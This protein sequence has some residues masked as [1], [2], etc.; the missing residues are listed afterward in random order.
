MALDTQVGAGDLVETAARTAVRAH[1]VAHASAD[2]D[3]L[4][5]AAEAQQIAGGWPSTRNNRGYQ[6]G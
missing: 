6:D 4:A 1:R 5:A 3:A 2:R